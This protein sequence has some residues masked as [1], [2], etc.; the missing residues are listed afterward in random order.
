MFQQH[1]TLYCLSATCIET[2]S[3]Y[4]VP[5]V[6]SMLVIVYCRKVTETETQESQASVCNNFFAFPYFVKYSFSF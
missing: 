1:G 3:L 5:L 2:K 4:I 6:Q